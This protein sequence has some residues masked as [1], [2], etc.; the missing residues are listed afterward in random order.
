[1]EKSHW[2]QSI[3]FFAFIDFVGGHLGGLGSGLRVVWG[4]TVT[5][6]LPVVYLQLGN[7]LVAHIKFC[8]LQSR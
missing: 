2:F 6:P 5:L 8:F 7:C 3:L 1:M 4:A